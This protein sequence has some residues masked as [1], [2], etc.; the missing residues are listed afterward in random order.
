MCAIGPLAEPATG[1][2]LLDPCSQNSIR[3]IA[4]RSELNPVEECTPDFR[5]GDPGCIFKIEDWENDRQPT[6]SRLLCQHSGEFSLIRFPQDTAVC[7]LVHRH[8]E[9]HQRPIT[10]PD[11]QLSLPQQPG[12]RT[13]FKMQCQD[14]RRLLTSCRHECLVAGFITELVV[15]ISRPSERAKNQWVGFD[16]DTAGNPDQHLQQTRPRTRAQLCS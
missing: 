10:T 5:T 9:N 3:L 15:V 2:L 13:G 14:S 4:R 1:N 11:R 8:P 6:A 16:V 7:P 12:H